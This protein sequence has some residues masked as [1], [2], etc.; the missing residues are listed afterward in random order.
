V[1]QYIRCGA[2]ILFDYVIALILF[3][4]FLYPFIGLTGDKLYVWLPLYSFILFLLAFYIIY[5]EMKGQG[6]KEKKPQNNMNPY[7]LKGA[8]YGLFGIIPLSFAVAVIAAVPIKDTTLG[9]LRH[10]AVNMILGPLY[11]FFRWLNETL[12]GYI[13]A[14]LLI[15]VISALGYLAGYFG[16][17]LKNKLFGK[18]ETVR[19]PEFKKSPWNPTFNQKNTGVKKKK[20]K[21]GKQ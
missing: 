4:V 15:P 3:V 19:E 7:P 16:F 1:K 11:F 14:I 2:R 5:A 10:I 8:V 18:K 21:N 20:K 12:L 13:A 9:N 6:I 17:N